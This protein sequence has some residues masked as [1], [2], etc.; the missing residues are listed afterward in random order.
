[1]LFYD[2]VAQ[3]KAY[4]KYLNQT[5]TSPKVLGNVDSVVG[6]PGETIAY[7]SKNRIN[8]YL[9]QGYELV[10]DSFANANDKRF[11]SEKQTDQVFS[12]QLIEKVLTVTAD[13]PKPIAGNP[14][15]AGDEL[16]PV[17]PKSVENLDTLRKMTK[18][19][20]HYKYQ[21]DGRQAFKDVVRSVV[22]E[23]VARVNL[24][25]GA[26]TYDNWKITRIMI[27]Q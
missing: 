20:I 21:K 25:T 10:H 2:Y 27:N 15:V 13:D 17:W 14:L 12:V 18:Q 3:Q 8:Q 19:T 16:S 9:K 6:L 26:V 7:N 23:R 4:V 24:V 1:M 11:D 22:F 5:E